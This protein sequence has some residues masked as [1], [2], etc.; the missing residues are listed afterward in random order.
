M[1]IEVDL[2]KA[3]RKAQKLGLGWRSAQRIMRDPTKPDTVRKIAALVYRL[4]MKK[5]GNVPVKRSHAFT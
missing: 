3:A 1:S 2:H 5:T 4:E